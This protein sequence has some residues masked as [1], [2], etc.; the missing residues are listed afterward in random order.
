MP[1]EIAAQASGEIVVGG[2][3]CH[4]IE[5]Y[6][7]LSGKRVWTIF[8]EPHGCEGRYLDL[9]GEWSNLGRQFQGS[10]ESAAREF[11]LEQARK[12]TSHE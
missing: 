6:L 9:N 3:V 5:G 7:Q 11:A 10:S 2:R 8:D 1:D 4:F 12:G